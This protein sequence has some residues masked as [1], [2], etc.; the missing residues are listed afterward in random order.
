[1]SRTRRVA[2]AVTASLPVASALFALLFSAT[3]SLAQSTSAAC[4]EAAQIAVLP[5]PI[6]PWKGAPLRVVFAAEKPLQGELS[7]I[8]PDGSVAAKSRGRYGGPPYFWFAE[9]ASPAAGT[10][11][12]QLASSGCSA[13]TREIIVADI[14]PPRPHST[15]GSVW[16]VRGR[17]TASRAMSPV[18]AKPLRR[19]RNRAARR[20]GFLIWRR[21]IRRARLA[22]A[23]HRAPSPRRQ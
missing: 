4:E 2:A 15:P 20:G 10:W 14:A 7:L 13:I 17:A 22:K 9:I 12:A 1:M 11:H 18:R 23:R 19:T 8:A 16:P 5:A 6:A 21:P 3:D